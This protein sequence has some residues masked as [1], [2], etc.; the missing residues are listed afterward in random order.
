MENKNP[1][2]KAK[3]VPKTA[4]AVK[5]SDGQ[6]GPTGKPAPTA[7]DPPTKPILTAGTTKAGPKVNPVP[8]KKAVVPKPGPTKAIPL[9]SKKS[10][11]H[12]K[13][14]HFRRHYGKRFNLK[15]YLLDAF[16]VVSEFFYF[17]FAGDFE[18]RKKALVD[19]SMTYL[20]YN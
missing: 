20:H 13:K 19:A 9:P 5:E 16:S 2:E 8:A 1:Q 17:V 3:L 4:A 10:I 12:R 11:V 14:H 6:P 18:P 7:E 15:N